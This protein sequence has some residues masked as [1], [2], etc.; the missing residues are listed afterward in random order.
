MVMVY[1]AFPAV[2]RCPGRHTTGMQCRGNAAPCGTENPCH[3][4][5]REGFHRISRR[6][7][8]N[9]SLP[10]PQPWLSPR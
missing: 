5:R 1:Q 8:R 6:Y 4:D 3:P 7:P 9:G 10:A 2:C